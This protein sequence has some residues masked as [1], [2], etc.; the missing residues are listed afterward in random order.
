MISDRQE[1]SMQ[2]KHLQTKMFIFILLPMIVMLTVIIVLNY[3]NM[4]TIYT[5]QLEA[6][7]K[8]KLQIY[9]NDFN[10]F[11]MEKGQVSKDLALFS[12]T[13]ELISTASYPLEDRHN[14]PLFMTTISD[15]LQLRNAD[16]DKAILQ[17]FMGLEN[18]DE[19]Y[20]D[21]W[22]KR[23]GTDLL[24]IP[25]D[26]F[27]KE[28]IDK[29]ND[30]SDKKIIQQAYRITSDTTAYKL[31][32][33][34]TLSDRKDILEIMKKAG[35][36]YHVT[37]RSW[38]KD[39]KR[40]QEFCFSNAYIDTSL[41]IP[42]VSA[43]TPIFDKDNQMTGA[44]GADISLEYLTDKIKELK[45]EGIE[46]N[47]T[48]LVDDRGYY[49]AYAYPDDE[50]K[51]NDKIDV[52]DK[53]TDIVNKIQK[54]KGVFIKAA[55]AYK[56][57]SLIKIGNDIEYVSERL[58][59]LA[60]ISA[61]QINEYN[62]QNYLAIIKSISQGKANEDDFKRLSEILSK[63]PK[64]ITTENAYV[65]TVNKIYKRGS[66]DLQATE[67]E[68][69]VIKDHLL[70]INNT[71]L[72]NQQISLKTDILKSIESD[73]K[74]EIA[75]AL[76]PKLIALGQR[77]E[78]KSNLTNTELILINDVIASINE[79]KVFKFKDS[80]Q[81][82]TLKN[83]ADK[84]KK[85]SLPDLE[86]VSFIPPKMKDVTS[87]EYYQNKPEEYYLIF[88]PI[89]TVKW[90]I[91]LYVSKAQALKPVNEMLRASLILSVAAII[92][93]ILIIVFLKGIILQPIQALAKGMK[94]V[95]GIKFDAKVEVKSRDE[96]GQMTNIYNLM[97][98]GLQERD[99]KLNNLISVS[100][101][102]A[103]E[104]ELQALLDLIMN[105]STDLLEADI[106]TIYL[107]D[108]NYEYLVHEVSK[109]WPLEI[110][111]TFKYKTG[112]G[113]VGTCA[114][115]GHIL[116]I[117]DAYANDLFDQNTDKQSGYRT[118]NI[119]CVP[120]ITTTGKTIGVVELKNKIGEKIFNENDE[121]LLSAFTS[122]ASISI[123]NARTLKEIKATMNTFQLFVPPKFL[124]RIAKEGVGNIKV[125]N[126]TQETIS[127]L[128]SDIRN[129]TSMS[130]KMTPEEVFVFLNEYMEEMNICIKANDG[131]I[132]KFI[133]DAIMALFDGK[134]ADGA[135]HAAI[136]MNIR[137]REYNKKRLMK[138]EKPIAIGCGVNTGSAI[139]GTLGSSDRMDGTVIGDCVN[140]ASRLEGLTKMYGSTLLISSFTKNV[141]EHPEN[142]LIRE[143][144]AVKV[145]GKDEIVTIYEVFN[146][147]S[148]DLIEAKLKSLPILNNAISLYRLRK[149]DEAIKLFKECEEILKND[150]VVISYIDRIEQHKISAPLD[151]WDGSYKFD[152]K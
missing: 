121:K 12:Q 14:D 127:I 70:K 69:S 77:Y 78:L 114:R 53:S 141:L 80:A 81:Y 8:K 97:L 89:P 134:H 124:E 1:K 83:I 118:K 24:T 108:K 21:N 20:Y 22:Q 139:I 104:T 50:S 112:I 96:I 49:I 150:K 145:K 138:G 63:L 32:N 110:V 86:T 143:I 34:S 100:R 85:I 61:K 15:F 137:L 91:G 64:Q 147:D 116:N 103:T 46:S 45:I 132:D 106:G 2:I 11:L 152:H 44:V 122:L 79:T 136:D 144:D 133:G 62:L 98:D 54:E 31:K 88:M 113:L 102:I 47:Y 84:Y 93:L 57:K 41:L 135:V 37:S 75:E 52:E 101:T 6:N 38:Y 27:H 67:Q 43:L 18:T 76:Y 105:N 120:I 19:A 128:F 90:S 39:V 26:A 17:I 3:K 107:Y 115:Q 36:G 151:D 99:T 92:I 130:E 28:I 140:L 142:F 13:K 42:V 40:K 95:E 129:F 125:G 146:S 68:C 33:A 55:A 131:F 149:W 48:F 4:Q 109:G 148:T 56:K 5:E 117:P 119:L 126:A 73:N 51:Y 29:L 60:N 65:S 66:G 25:R 10:G 9:T 74:F 30:E 82:E 94:E 111:K 71:F 58:L 16:K 7:M 59:T 35:Y 87:S 23:K 72:D 123:E